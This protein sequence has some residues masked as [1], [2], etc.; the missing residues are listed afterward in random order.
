MVLAYARLAGP[1]LTAVLDGPAARSAWGAAVTSLA[2]LHQWAA[3]RHERWLALMPAD[4]SASRLA[5]YDLPV[6]ALLRPFHAVG[7]ATPELGTAIERARQA[8][9]APGSWLAFTHGDLQTRHLLWTAAGLRI[10]DWEGAGLR[11]RLYDLACLLDKPTAHG[12]RLPQTAHD[13]AIMEYARLCGLDAAAVRAELIPVLAYERLIAVAEDDPTQPA[14][15][16][17]ALEG[18]IALTA[19]APAYAAI[20]HAAGRLLETLPEDAVPFFA[21]FGDR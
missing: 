10:V 9:A 20:G 1:E 11:H 4:R 12:R 15:N 16:R 21:G 13:G 2:A 6:E 19:P 7:M 5:A 17:A 18:L 14:L 8:V 3:T